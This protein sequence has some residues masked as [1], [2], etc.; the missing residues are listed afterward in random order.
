M[1]RGGSTNIDFLS[2]LSGMFPKPVSLTVFFGSCLVL[3]LF[4]VTFL[5]VDLH[6]KFLPP[7]CMDQG[8][9]SQRRL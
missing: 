3:L 1:T 8:S 2:S 9:G 6:S 5:Y 7:V 4:V